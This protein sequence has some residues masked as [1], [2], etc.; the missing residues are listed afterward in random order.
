MGVRSGVPEG[1]TRG[2][3]GGQGGQGG[4]TSFSFQTLSLKI[5][6]TNFRSV[7]SVK[8]QRRLKSGSKKIKIKQLFLFKLETL[9]KKKPIFTKKH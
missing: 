9:T 3:G 8:Q 4:Q 2:G 7:K 5:S 6:R 1:Q